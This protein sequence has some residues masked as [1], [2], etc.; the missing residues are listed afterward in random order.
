MDSLMGRLL[1]DREAAEI[2][3]VAARG[4]YNVG[5]LASEYGVSTRTINNILTDLSYRRPTCYPA[6][7]QGRA[8][9]EQRQR[10]YAA[11]QKRKRQNALCVPLQT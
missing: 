5:S 7:S 9:A 2:R 6:G 1:T 10:D 3:V 4:E 11:N 8:D